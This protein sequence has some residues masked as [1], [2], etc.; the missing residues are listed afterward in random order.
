M[1][2]GSCCSP[3]ASLRVYPRDRR[4]RRRVR[5]RGAVRCFAEPLSRERSGGDSSDLRI[6]RT[7]PRLR[8]GLRKAHLRLR[9]KCIRL[10]AFSLRGSV[11]KSLRLRPA[12]GCEQDGRAVGKGPLSV[13]LLRQSLPFALTLLCTLS[14]QGCSFTGRQDFGLDILVLWA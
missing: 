4:C 7:G 9:K 8:R 10:C 3:L 2:P 13:E 1:S 11:T 14:C 12:V 6:R 5:C